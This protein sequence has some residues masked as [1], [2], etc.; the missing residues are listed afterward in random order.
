MISYEQVKQAMENPP[1]IDLVELYND[2]CESITKHPD[3]VTDSNPFEKLFMNGRF[4]ISATS[5]Q[6]K[7]IAFVLGKHVKSVFPDDIIHRFFDIRCDFKIQFGK[8]FGNQIDGCICLI[9]R[10]NNNYDL[11]E[12]YNHIYK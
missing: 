3:C 6:S 11:Q 10:E 4:C 1:T 8:I 9:H 2:L 12:I 5:I 7:Y